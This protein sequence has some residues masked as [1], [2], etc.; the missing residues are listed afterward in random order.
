MLSVESKAG[1]SSFR[2]TIR[3]ILGFSDEEYVT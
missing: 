3:P 2:R 1:A